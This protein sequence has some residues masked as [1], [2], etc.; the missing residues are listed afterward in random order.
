[1]A[2]TLC[3]L[4]C[5]DFQ[6]SAGCSEQACKDGGVC[7]MYLSSNRPSAHRRVTHETKYGSDC[8][9]MKMGEFSAKDANLAILHELLMMRE[10]GCEYENG[11]V[12]LAA[13]W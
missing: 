8:G 3:R 11:V 10:G 4:K 12:T 6:R 9:P 13:N 2:P 7:M 5:A 1:M